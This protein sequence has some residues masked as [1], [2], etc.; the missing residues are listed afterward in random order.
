MKYLGAMAFQLS[1]EALARM[2]V[3][4]SC[5]VHEGVFRVAP[6][7]AAD[8]DIDPRFDVDVVA[9]FG[10]TIMEATRKDEVET[11]GIWLKTKED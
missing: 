4:S 11:V 1:P 10:I 5:C 9:C 3:S 8:V 2:R 7:A 6:E